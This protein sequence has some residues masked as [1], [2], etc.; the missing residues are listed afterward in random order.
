MIRNFGVILGIASLFALGACGDDSGTTPKNDKGGIRLDGGGP[1]PDNGGIVPDTGSV[2]DQTCT[3]ILTCAA[4]CQ[5]ATCIAACVANGTPKAQTD[6][7]A[8]LGCLDTAAAGSCASDCA[9]PSA[10]ACQT[11]VQAACK[12]ESDV[13][14][15]G[16]GQPDDGF[17]DVCDP[18]NNPCKNTALTCQM[19]QG[20]GAGFCT[21]KCDSLGPPCPGAPT[22]LA[23]YCFIQDQS[24]Q[25][26]CGFVCKI[27]GQEYPCPTGLT[28]GAEQ[29]GQAVCQ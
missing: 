7:N 5:D 29:Q 25:Y 2:A 1:T 24:Q 20:G 3:Q 18:T 28:C 23:S 11:C 4:K 8:Y 26:W 21:K 9:T 16:T 12:S 6:F 17:G 13:C 10:P 22:G 15:G 14:A 19:L 27:G